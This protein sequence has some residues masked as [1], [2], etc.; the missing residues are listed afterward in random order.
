M[1]ALLAALP[2]LVT[3]GL[4][5][6]KVRAP[7][8]ALAAI[9]TAAALTTTT[10]HTPVAD[11]GDAQLRMLPVLVELAAIL[12]GGILLSELM[13]RT[14]AQAAL[15][16][17]LG[18]ACGSRSRAVLL[19]VFGVTPFAESLTG[20]GIGVVVAVPLLRQLGLTP[21]KAAITGLLGLVTVPWGSLA[22]GSLVSAEL[23]RVDF[24]QL[25]VVSALL[26]APV[27]LICGAAALTVAV[28]PRHA[29]RAIGELLL[30]AGTLWLALWAVNTYVGVP[31]AGVLGGLATLAVLLLV[32]RLE[33]R[34]TGIVHREPVGR[35]LAPYAFLVT[36]LLIGRAALAAT[37][38]ERGWWTV[39]AGPAGWL[40]LTTA[41]TP[42]LLGARV[43]VLP[44]AIR[45]TA[46]RWWQVTL[47]TALFLI[48]G[49]LLTV[50]GMSREM[51]EAC[52]ALGP[53]YLMIAPWIGAVGGFLTGSNTGAN[54]MF[55]A[56]Q[57]ATAHA[58]G[59]PA[60][61][62]VGIQ[63]VSAAL[64]SGGSIARVVLAAELASNSPGP[65]RL[66]PE[67]EPKPTPRHH[68]DPTTTTTTTLTTTDTAPV[69]T[70]RVL[71]T[72]LTAH[73]AVFLA[74]GAVALIRR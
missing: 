9:G 54:A 20:F 33:V 50:T 58:L 45:T 10:F 21:T 64:A 55:A 49:T 71:W 22:P 15:G 73:A 6:A 34:A 41:L 61:H 5:A 69:D 14:G 42:R 7:Y 47:T 28:G 68:L 57:S 29:L 60:L 59:Y 12:F 11:L 70:A 38:I 26:S 48:L 37:G 66:P 46:A 17:R 25:G 23:G 19:I 35:A 39:V 56:G 52:A 31:L 3:L 32:S 63:N 67:N 2:I 27:F 72:V 16:D 43:P 13:T 74:L 4:V 44:D 1:N 30:A 36:G 53:A 62:L 24:Q 65:R 18:G 40:L 51:A 8:A